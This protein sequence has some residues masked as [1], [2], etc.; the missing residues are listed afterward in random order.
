MFHQEISR[1]YGRGCSPDQLHY[2]IQNTIRC[3]HP[4]IWYDKCLPSMMAQRRELV[5]LTDQH[6]TQN[7]IMNMDEDDILSTR[8]KCFPHCERPNLNMYDTWI[9]MRR[10]NTIT[11]EVECT[12]I[13]GPVVTG[14]RTMCNRSYA[15]PIWGSNGCLT[16]DQILWDAHTRQTGVA[17]KV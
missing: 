13:C 15:Y 14:I 8:I 10:W 4:D 11:G 6:P 7:I 17:H 1:G 5:T 2:S 3:F 16:G 12:F 9:Q